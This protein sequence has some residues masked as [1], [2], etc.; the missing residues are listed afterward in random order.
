M[1]TVYKGI[2]ASDTNLLKKTI[3]N[4]KD[5]IWYDNI[6]ILFEYNRIT[7]FFPSSDM[8]VEEQLNSCVRLSL[9]ISIILV[10]HSGNVNMLLL[11][12]F[13]LVFTYLIYKYSN[14]ESP[15]EGYETYNSKFVKPTLDNP[16]MNVMLNDYKNNPN[17]E[18]LN[19]ANSYINKELNHEVANKYNYNLYRDAGDIFDR[20]ANQRQFYTMPVTT[21]PNRQDHFS[22]WLYSS[23][24][25]C[26]EGN[27]TSCVRG[28]FEHLKDS[29]IRNGI[30]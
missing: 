8:T 7:E 24:P 28:N 4:E 9:Y 29:E 2:N 1:T 14:R 17:R 5:L 25:T 11:F 22:N 26:K 12:L 3:V 23:P 18:A 20:A 6:Y 19:K 27:G 10:I 16:F 30:F 15:I 21:I 13:T